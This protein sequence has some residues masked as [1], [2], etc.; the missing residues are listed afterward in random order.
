LVTLYPNRG[1]VP[2]TL[3]RSL[4]DNATHHIDVLVFSGLF[5]PDGYPEVAKLIAAKAEEGTKVRLALGDP[6]CDAVRL[7]GVASQERCKRPWAQAPAGS[8]AAAVTVWATTS[9]S[10][11]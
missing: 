6:D 11:L 5:L 7:R 8:Y 2:G 3:W 9:S 1:A 4:L 10:S